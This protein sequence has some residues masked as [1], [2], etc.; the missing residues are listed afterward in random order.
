VQNPSQATAQ[1]PPTEQ[2]APS[3]D[4]AVERPNRQAIMQEVWDQLIADDV[5]T[6][7]QADAIQDAF[8][9]RMEE[10]REEFDGFHGRRGFGF[11]GPGAEVRGLLADGVIDTDELT[12]LGE[13]HPFNDPDGPFADA[14]ADGEITLEELEALRGTLGFG[15]GERGF[16]DGNGSGAES[17]FNA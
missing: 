7:E 16:G 12:E 17:G 14:A 8:R 1:E 13:D 10:L 2:D 6:Q 15:R 3:N 4:T 9:Q 11:R 5:V